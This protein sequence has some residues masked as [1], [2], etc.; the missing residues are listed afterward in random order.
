MVSF[1][2]M[3]VQG[4]GCP[5]WVDFQMLSIYQFIF[6]TVEYFKVNF[7]RKLILFDSRLYTSFDAS[8]NNVDTSFVNNCFLNVKVDIFCFLFLFWGV[9]KH[10][11]LNQI[12]RDIMELII[13]R[14]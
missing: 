11:Y 12:F 7:S 10:A 2:V 6:I 13:A 9:E 14:F 4:P 8:S 1:Q 5:Y 3:L